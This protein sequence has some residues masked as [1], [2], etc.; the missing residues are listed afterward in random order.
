[1]SDSAT[2]SRPPLVGREHEISLLIEGL[3]NAGRGLGTLVWI[4]GESG[5]GKTRLAQEIGALAGARGA[6]VLWSR[7]LE[8]DGAPPYWPWAEIL[9]AFIRERSRTDFDAIVGSAADRLS[10]LVPE[11]RPTRPASPQFPSTETGSDRFL[12]FEAVR[13]FLQRACSDRL[14]VVVIDDVHHAGRNSLLLLEFIAR[15]LIDWKALI[16]LTSRD[17]EISPGV[18]QTFGEL[19]RV[20]LQD[21]HLTGVGVEH[22]RQLIAQV[23]GRECSEELAS[24]VH[25]RTRGNPFF[26]TEIAH[27]QP[28]D[29]AAIPETVRAALARRLSRFSDTTCH[30]LVVCSV[31]GQAFDFRLVKSVLPEVGEA[32]LLAGLEEALYRRVIEPVPKR[33]E[34]WYQFRHVLMR[35]ALYESASPS[36]R[37]QW[38]AAILERIEEHH[39]PL[40][41]ARAEE[42]AYHASAA[43]ALVGSSRVVTYCRLA[44]ER[45]IA[46]YAFEEALPHFE[47]A[48]RARNAARRGGGRHP[49]RAGPGPGGHGASLEPAGGLDHSPARHRVLHGSRRSRPS[50]RSRDAPLNLARGC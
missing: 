3:E 13:T 40:L 50:R 9:R 20:G 7:C 16:V 47:R 27:L 4:S 45:M 11:L 12:I 23:S 31:M 5:V 1:M 48:W 49:G 14:L 38:H 26:V 19:A 34:N 25:V 18:R 15:E 33:G 28:L 43:E 37:A 46:A 41:E 6:R 44:G 10:I 30:L 8:V 17:D 39:R 42:L 24:L 35:D 29:G 32:D 22:T 21:L 36:R 2:P